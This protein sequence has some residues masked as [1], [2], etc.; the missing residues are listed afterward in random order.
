MYVIAIS[1][2]Y[3]KYSNWHWNFIVFL[4]NC[5]GKIRI[6]GAQGVS[7]EAIP[8]PTLQGCAWAV[9]ANTAGGLELRLIPEELQLNPNF[10][11]RVI[12]KQNATTCYHTD[13]M[14][15]P[16]TFKIFT[17]SPDLLK[18]LFYY[19]SAQRQKCTSSMCNSSSYSSTV[20]PISKV[21]DFSWIYGKLAEEVVQKF[22]LSLSKMIH[23]VCPTVEWVMRII[24]HTS[25]LECHQKGKAST[26]GYPAFRRKWT[27]TGCLYSG[28]ILPNLI[29]PS[30]IRNLNWRSLSAFLESTIVHTQV[31]IFSF[32]YDSLQAYGQFS[33]GYF[34]SSAS[35]YAICAVFLVGSQ[36]EWDWILSTCYFQLGDKIGSI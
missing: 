3:S 36:S 16:T 34:S 35:E 32:S 21:R 5:G 15:E 31:L 19:S 18:L 23:S 4:V 28:L 17:E 2:I 13:I 29:L 14:Y 9:G 6:E 10:T 7:Y 11:L 8:T 1:A 27:M 30:A 25:S 33:V 12:Y 24:R 20:K 26:C 22:S